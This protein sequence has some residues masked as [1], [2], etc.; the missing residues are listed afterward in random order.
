MNRNVTIFFMSL[1]LPHIAAA[2]FCPTNF[3]QIN[4]G[5]PLDVVIKQCGA[6]AE[7]KKIPPDESNLP[8]QWSY[9]VTTGSNAQASLKMDVALNNDKVVNITANGMSLAATTICGANIKVGDSSQTV[10]KACGKPIYVTKSQAAPTTPPVELIQLQ[11]NS[12]PPAI[13]IF[14]NGKLKERK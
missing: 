10:Q 6:P 9:Y 13:F 1:F 14:E 2:M 12:S 5:D 8:Q 11:Y 7:Q 3:N 4:L